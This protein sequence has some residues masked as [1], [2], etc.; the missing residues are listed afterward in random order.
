M[1]K[2]KESFFAL[3]L[4][5][6]FSFIFS[7][8]LFSQRIYAEQIG[9]ARELTKE[10]MGDFE[11]LTFY[12]TEDNNLIGTIPKGEES[13]ENSS[14]EWLKDHR[15]LS[16][17][18][19]DVTVTYS[20]VG[21]FHGKDIDAEIVFT[22]FEKKP[23]TFLDRERDGKYIGIPKSFRGDFEY[24][25]NSVIQKI[26]FF[27][28]DDNSKTP[29]DMSRAFIVINGLNVDE[30]AGMTPGHDAY[31]SEYS[32]LEYKT[33][34]GFC[35]YGNG[36]QAL[37]DNDMKDTDDD[38]K[39]EKDGK[40]YDDKN[41]KDYYYV[42]SVM[43]MLNG[44]EN[45]LYIEDKRETGGFGIRWC[46][47]LTTLHVTYN[48]QTEVENGTISDPVSG[49]I[50]N[51]D[52]RI[53]YSPK[54]DYVL[55][56]ISV[57]DTPIDKNDENVLGHY[58]FKNITQDHK[59]SVVY[60]L[61]YKKIVTE[62][63]NGAITP[64]DENILFGTDKK[65]DY[66]PSEGYVLDNITVDEENVDESQYKNS[67]SFTNIRD[68]H[69]I[70]VVYSKPEAPVKKVLDKNGQFI[71]GK[72][73][74]PGDTLTYEISY[75]NPLEREAL[76]TITDSLPLHTEF[77]SATENGKAEEGKVIWKITS[78]PKGEG[79]V[80]LK[81]KVKESAK[82][83]ILTNYALMNIADVN[84]MSNKVDNPVQED[85]EKSILDNKGKD[86]NNTILKRGQE[87]TYRITL[88][89]IASTEKT[90]TIKDKIPEGMDFVSA[91]SGGELKDREVVWEVKLSS[92][93]EKQVSFKAKA[94]ADDKTFINQATVSMDGLNYLTNKTENWTPKK[95]AKEVKQNGISVNGK[96][97]PKGETVTY[98]ITVKNPASKKMDIR[99]EDKVSDHLEILSISDGGKE[100]DNNISWNLEGVS[101]G[102]SRVVTFEAKTK[103]DE[104]SHEVK[105]TA[106]MTVGNVKLS[107][108]E[109][110][111]K[112]PAVKKM[113]VKGETAAP[114]QQI[115]PN[116]GVLGERK[117]PTGDDSN[118][119]ALILTA[120]CALA[121]LV[122]VRVKN[123]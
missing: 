11:K 79:K 50:Y 113:E 63:V 85:P 22:G 77:E 121:G 44:T 94:A 54:P 29:I 90:A 60:K 87:I 71:N 45:D 99:I 106:D 46:L 35:C 84:L 88:K 57:D 25:G 3:L 89:N 61:P 40:Y 103:G 9:D 23:E 15:L 122:I 4:V 112:I 118:I 97:I 86:I 56:S 1:A 17:E 42:C 66:S 78:S 32:T 70:K 81:V 68:D 115:S 53:T 111:I 75:K 8:D 92:K 119:L 39:F 27:Y 116:S 101:P 20:H 48:I 108:N 7:G 13:E 55:D 34:K 10:D 123:V 80:L 52:Q 58:D 105:N 59:I 26:R 73:V 41:S 104:D 74:M 117:V 2:L 43:F 21:Q 5:S 96:S 36:V 72:N 28:S 30:Y 31:V 82:G 62:V 38:K 18:E 98:Y 83:N 65:I 49:I 102:G 120:M 69:R 110:S 109:V 67:Y 6:V 114:V 12:E 100:D 24:D 64:S 33:E 19:G 95:P 91:D 76:I 93:E 37:N 16:T 107:T 47:D 51:T 14:Y